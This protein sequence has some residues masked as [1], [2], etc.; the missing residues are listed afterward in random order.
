MSAAIKSLAGSLSV[1]AALTLA[2]CGGGTKTVTVSGPPPTTSSP[3]TRTGTQPTTPT[4]TSSSSSSTPSEPPTRFVHLASFQSPT[5]NIGCML[6]A[7]IARCDIEKRDWS[8]PP[9]PASCPNVVDFGQGLELGGS[10]SAR[11]VCAG[12]TARDI[13]SPKLPYGTASEVGD[14]VCVSRP[15]GITCTSRFNGHG[16]LISIQSYRLF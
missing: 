10:G 15:T 11:F 16:F 5:G 12:D 3:S 6:I 9:R 1:A 4:P 8:P 14:F 2:A 13:T 7:G